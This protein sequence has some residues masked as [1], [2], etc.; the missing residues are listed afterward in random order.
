MWDFVLENVSQFVLLI[1][2]HRRLPHPSRALCRREHFLTLLAASYYWEHDS[3][4]CC[5]SSHENYELGDG[6]V[7][8]SRRLYGRRSERNPER[9]IYEHKGQRLRALSSRRPSQ[10]LRVRRDAGKSRPRAPTAASLH[11]KSD[12]R[13]PSRL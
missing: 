3:V 11:H 1:I 9:S 13:I 7:L 12:A 6:V 10:H 8:S 2:G 4:S 5:R